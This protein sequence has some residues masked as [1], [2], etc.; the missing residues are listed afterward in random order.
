MHACLTRPQPIRRST[1]LDYHRGRKGRS[2]RTTGPA[3]DRDSVILSK[4][5][6]FHSSPPRSPSP[7]TSYGTL[8]DE[9]L[10]PISHPP[11]LRELCTYS[12]S[13][14]QRPKPYHRCG[15]NII[16]RLYGEDCVECNGSKNVVG[17]QGV[18]Q[19]M[20]FELLIIN[21]LILLQDKR[22]LERLTPDALAQAVIAIQADIEWRR[23]RALAAALH[24]D[25]VNQRSKFIGIT[26]KSEAETYANA[27]AEPFE[28]AVKAL[29]SCSTD[30]LKNHGN[31]SIAAYER[32]VTSFATADTEFDD[33]EN[34][35]CAYFYLPAS[36]GTV[37][38][39]LQ[40]VNL[41]GSDV[42]SDEEDDKCSENSGIFSPTLKSCNDCTDLAPQTLKDIST[43]RPS[44]LGVR[45]FEV[46]PDSQFLVV[47]VTSS[48]VVSLFIYPVCCHSTRS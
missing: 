45:T 7:N 1:S 14:K 19:S 36:D 43:D 30:E 26:V 11:I 39:S 12:K 10:G 31:S 8:D 3:R 32:D 25:A 42:S 20:C 13:A 44:L 27:A 16:E 40:A 22:R 18:C 21:M 15:P 6:N 29:A 17:V 9:I 24:V 28:T 5:T 41:L 34:Y 48:A 23:V 37:N 46:V 38:S 47:L 33:V 4:A 35:A 2:P